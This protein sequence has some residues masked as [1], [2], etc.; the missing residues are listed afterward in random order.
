[1]PRSPSN[2]VMHEMIRSMKE[3][4]LPNMHH[5]IT[6]RLDRLNGKVAEHEKFIGEHRG[7]IIV[8][9]WLLG[10]CIALGTLALALLKYFIPDKP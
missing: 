8:G 5:E 10:V 1:M 3:D 7:A 4:Q 6:S 2:D 9:K